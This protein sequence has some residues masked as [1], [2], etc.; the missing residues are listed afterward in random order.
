MRDRA[1]AAWNLAA[2]VAIAATVFAMLPDQSAPPSSPV[3][4]VDSEAHDPPSASALPPVACGG[5]EVRL[6]FAGDIMQHASQAA[7]SYDASYERVAPILRRSDVVVGNLEFPVVPSRPA[8]PDGASVQFNGSP[9]H[10]DAIARAGFT[11][12]SLS[13]NHAFDQGLDGLRETMTELQKR[14]LAYVGAATDRSD[15]EQALVMQEVRGVRIA[16]FAYTSL[17]NTYLANE[18]DFADPP[19]DLPLFFA[20]F[21]EWSDEYRD[22][23]RALFRRHVERARHAGA[24]LV[25]ALAHW[26][27]EWRFGPTPDQRAAAVDLVDAGFDLVV[28]GHG[29]VLNTPEIVGGK[30]V[31]YSLGDFL[32]DFA[33]WQA[34]TGAL[35]E[36]VA[37]RDADNVVRIADFRFRPVLVERERHVI[38]PLEAPARTGDASSASGSEPAP[39]TG[40]EPAPAADESQLAWKLAEKL[41]GPGLAAREPACPSAVREPS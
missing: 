8:G 13:N 23:G 11:L 28:G 6:A 21:A 30:L 35:L 20:N 36:V 17:L 1:I 41:L 12:L 32:C 19:A 16:F 33:E 4:F 5:D 9:A 34:R 27:D 10:L 3:V 26:G 24:D 15:L 40:S 37:R 29:H 14:S 7:D 18:F 2:A 25:V 22:S 39:A 38:M 31:V